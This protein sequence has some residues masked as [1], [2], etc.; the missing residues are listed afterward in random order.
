MCAL[1]LVRGEL[2]GTLELSSCNKRWSRP[3]PVATARVLEH[4]DRMNEP[5]QL[6]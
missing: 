5:T 4:L 2:G 1:G 6:N 3:L